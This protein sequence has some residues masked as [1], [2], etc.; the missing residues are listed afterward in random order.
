M[1]TDYEEENNES[2]YDDDNKKFDKEKLKR[3]AFYVLI[4]VVLIILFVILAKGCS[5]SNNKKNTSMTDQVPTVVVGRESISLS[6][7]ESFSLDADVLLA[8]NSNP[9]INWYSEDS[10][11]ASVNEQGYIT[12]EA[13]GETN[14]VA[15]Y[16]QAG[17]I[18]RNSCKVTVT[19]NV[20]SPTNIDFGQD[21]VVIKKGESLLLQV[22]VSPSDAKVNNLVYSSDD[23][24]IASVNSKGY[25][26][27]NNVGTTTITVKTS[28]EK[29]SDTLT[30]KVVNSSSTERTPVTINP[31]S[32]NLTGLS[33]GLSVG[34]KA[35]VIY[36]IAPSN[37]TNKTVTWSSSNP[38]VATVSNGIV[39]GV[40]AGNCTIIATT[41]NNISSQLNI[42]VLPNTVS[43]TGITINGNTSISMNVGYTKRLY[44]T[45]TPSNATNKEVKYKSSNT[46]VIIVD[47]NGIMAAVGS[48]TAVV[49]V[50][51]KDGNKTAV[52]NVTVNNSTSPT[53]TTTTT[54]TGGSSTSSGSSGTTS[55]TQSSSNCNVNSVIIKSNQDGAV[56]SNLKFENAKA[57][58]NSDPGL[59][60]TSY[61]SCLKSVKYS[62]WYNADKNKLNTATSPTASGNFP[63][64]G[65][66]LY[67]NKGNG[68]Y[69][70]KVDVLTNSGSKYYK[71][72]YAIVNSSVRTS[73]VSKKNNITLAWT[74][75]CSSNKGT[76]NITANN[77]VSNIKKFSYCWTNSLSGCTSSAYTTIYNNINGTSS[78]T[79]SV[80]NTNNYN[81]LCMSATSKDGNSFQTC[82]PNISC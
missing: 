82:F 29:L 40:S 37:A 48:G 21:N 45:I 26:K 9:V 58:T 73:G 64:K 10:S 66:T 16:R 19:S 49:T 7:G 17:K 76:F 70:I 28:D 15:S 59:Y 72:Y 55:T 32:I 81:L 43:V 35:N 53:S 1:Y 24:N 42:T 54:T 47:S 30:I 61:D 77:T 2:Y 60:V 12:A 5:K 36:T 67:L 63:K 25:V 80:V 14:I 62:M 75:T 65:E 68:Y 13:E 31:T 33:S 27:A 41:S 18:Y 74:K 23:T 11:I 79:K 69:Y 22:T 38:S 8:S 39:T 3:I 52:A 46:N 51:T 50:T 71:Y 56:T 78:Y 34:G 4:S 57:F 44:W 20:V 6:V